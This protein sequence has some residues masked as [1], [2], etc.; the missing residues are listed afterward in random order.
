VL[1]LSGGLIVLSTFLPWNYGYHDE[2][3][4]AWELDSAAVHNELGRYVF[5]GWLI[6]A[7]GVLVALTGWLLARRAAAAPTPSYGSIAVVGVSGAVLVIDPTFY[8]LWALAPTGSSN[9]GIFVTLALA[10]VAG[11][12]AMLAVP[13]LPPKRPVGV[14]TIAARRR[15]G[16]GRLMAL[17]GGVLV[18]L[19]TW[20]PWGGGSL[21]DYSNRGGYVDTMTAGLVVRLGEEPF[22]VWTSPLLVLGGGLL[23]VAAVLAG[24]RI[25]TRR[26]EGPSPPMTVLILE[27]GV[28]AS[29]FSLGVS[30]HNRGTLGPLFAA[31]SGM[32]LAI[33]ASAIGLGGLLVALIPPRR[34]VVTPEL[35]APSEDARNTGQP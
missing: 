32:T 23:I 11:I 24:Q 25:R 17:T 4:S 20:M 31:G 13:R 10:T 1:T 33:A 30:L 28:L 21:W 12:A 9:Y 16:T 27:L 6:A 14:S 34:R 19:S 29:F 15:V 2:S 26:A 8:N 18:V 3:R 35:S 22:F 5:A 7:G